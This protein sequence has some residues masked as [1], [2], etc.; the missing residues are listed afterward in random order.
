MLAHLEI[1]PALTNSRTDICVESGCAS[2]LFWLCVFHV[3]SDLTARKAA[4]P[5]CSTT[6]VK[7]AIV[8]SLMVDGSASP[9]CR[10]FGRFR[11]VRMVSKRGAMPHQSVCGSGGQI[12]RWIGPRMH[13]SRCRSRLYGPEPSLH[14]VPSVEQARAKFHVFTFILRT[15]PKAGFCVMFSAG[16]HGE[17]A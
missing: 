17:P 12:V 6:R 7:S 8:L 3:G 15:E 14:V 9:D 11:P 4:L 1:V 16:Q 2:G 5:V 10:I 13:Q